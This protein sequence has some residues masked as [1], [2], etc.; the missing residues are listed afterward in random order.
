MNKEIFTIQVYD[1]NP[2]LSELD[3]LIIEIKE[4]LISF[5]ESIFYPVGGGQPGDTGK[6]VLSNGDEISIIDTFRDVLNPNQIWSKL[7]SR[8]DKIW[9]GK[10]VKT[11]IDWERRYDHMQMHTCMHLLCSLIDAPVTGCSISA[12][13]ARLDFDLP[14]PTINKDDITNSLNLLIDKGL[15]V[16]SKL[17]TKDEL[18]ERSE[19]IRTLEVS[20]PIYNNAIR[21]IEIENV[22][23]Q[24]CGG[25]HVSNTKEIKKVV[26]KK[27][28]KVSRLN[29]RIE[30]SWE[31]DSIE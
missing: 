27:I 31:K 28:K 23:L 14:D 24:P 20:P 4:D 17:I 12:S 16:K 3:S 19:I 7:D 26:C 8:L 5:D 13:K 29:R 1:F 11:Y 30:I 21:L 2:Y 18:E 10:I 6:I 25:T 22:D 9:E 15:K